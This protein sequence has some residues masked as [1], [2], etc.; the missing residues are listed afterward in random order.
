MLPKL[1]NSSISMREVM[2]TS[3]LQEFEGS[4]RFK[5]NNLGLAQGMV[6]EI[7]YQCSKRVKTKSQ[8]VLEGNSYVSRIYSGKTGRGAFLVHSSGIGLK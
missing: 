1:G 5:F 8:N 3:I 6:L 7:I 4:P 2:I